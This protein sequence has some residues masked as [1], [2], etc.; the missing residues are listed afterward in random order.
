M[1]CNDYSFYTDVLG[2]HEEAKLIEKPRTSVLPRR[3]NWTAPLEMSRENSGTRVINTENPRSEG[4]NEGPEFTVHNTHSNIYIVRI[5]YAICWCNVLYKFA[6]QILQNYAG[7]LRGCVRCIMLFCLSWFLVTHGSENHLKWYDSIVT[8]IPVISI[9][10]AQPQD[11]TKKRIEGVSRR[12]IGWWGRV[13]RDFGAEKRGM[14]NIQY[15][16]W[17]K[18]SKQAVTELFLIGKPFTKKD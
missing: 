10:R 14:S 11:K 8:T 15:D 2:G 12:E 4:A 18:F 9:N 13:E 16:S 17:I 6:Y 7:S 5:G 1:W 3:D